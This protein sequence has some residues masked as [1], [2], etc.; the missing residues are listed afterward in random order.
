MRFLFLLLSLSLGA[1]LAYGWMIRRP[2]QGVLR[3]LAKTAAVG[4]LALFVLLVGG[5]VLLVLALALSALGDLLLSRE[6][7]AAFLGGMVAFLAAHLAYVPFF[8]G[9]GDPSLVAARWPAMAALVLFGAGILRLLWPRLG[10]FRAPVVLYV[11]ALLAMGVAALALPFSGG[12]ALIPVGAGLF[13]LSDMILAVEKF[14]LPGGSSWR[15]ITPF[16]VWGLYWP[17][18]AMITFGAL[19]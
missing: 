5:P 17:A 18:Q 2:G 8:L 1:A 15:R 10:A 16:A 12:R 19:W 11:L 6:G 7:D 3:S 14:H 4:A 9:L 13:I